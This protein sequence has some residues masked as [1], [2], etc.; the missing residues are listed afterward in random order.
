[1]QF[2]KKPTET[3]NNDEYLKMTSLIKSDLLNNLCFECGSKNPNYISINNA[4][5]ICKNCIVNHLS[6][7][8]D[9]SQIIINDLYSLNF[10]EVK[11]LYLGGNRKLIHF[12]N[13]DFPGLKQLPP[14]ILYK[15]FAVDYY[16]KSLKFLVYGGKKPLKPLQSL[17]YDLIEFS[18]DFTNKKSDKYFNK[19][20]L[21]TIIEGKDEFDEKENNE[22]EDTFTKN[23]NNLEND[24]KNESTMINTPQK[25]LDENNNEDINN[26]SGINNNTENKSFQKE[27]NDNSINNNEKNINNIIKKYTRKSIRNEYKNK[28]LKNEKEEIKENLNINEEIKFN[29]DKNISEIL[30]NEENNSNNNLLNK[31]DIKTTKSNNNENNTEIKNNDNNNL[32]DDI[33]GDDN[34]IKIVN[35]LINISRENDISDFKSNKEYNND[36][37][38][39]LTKEKLEEE[40][41]EKIIKK[42]KKIS[43]ND[44]KSDIEHKRLK[45]E[46]DINKNKRKNVIDDKLKNKS[47]DKDHNY[48]KGKKEKYISDEEDNDNDDINEDE[49][50]ITIKKNNKDNN[51]KSIKTIKNEN[52]SSKSIIIKRQE[53]S[54]EEESEEEE[55]N[56]KL[57]L[58]EIVPNRHLKAKIK[59]SRIFNI[60]ND[61]NKQRYKDFSDKKIKTQ[62]IINKTERKDKYL[63]SNEITIKK[64]KKEKDNF[65]YNDKNAF[66]SG[67]INPLKYFQKSFQQKQNEKFDISSN[68]SEEEEESYEEEEEFDDRNEKNI[69]EK[70]GRKN[71]IVEVKVQRKKYNTYVDKKYSKDFSDN[72][73]DEEEVD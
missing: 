17:A 48:K 39:S 71:K 27:K 29:T 8:H 24:T 4:V 52:K 47:K 46:T 28:L 21:A 25:N 45:T 43:R 31:S 18:K 65:F 10:S 67:F 34:T 56:R 73:S 9:I 22:D 53:Y 62:K 12:I 37:L 50:K 35:G 51:N 26:N 33:S 23:N 61:D 3:N 6:F 32:N 38:S 55:K 49:I 54:S 44:N 15:T 16:R 64:E 63:N 57:N 40:I 19:T 41:K 42:D 30:N 70:I 20:E 11:M 58:T 68:S 5:F 66:N 59:T 1:M 14:E 69:K 7:P 2:Y 60:G 36:T 13:F 72:E